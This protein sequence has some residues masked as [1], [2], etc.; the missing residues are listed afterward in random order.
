MAGTLRGADILARALAEAGVRHLFSLSGNQIMPVYDAAPDAGLA[1]VH[2]RHEGAAVHMADAWGRLTGEPGI[3]LV[4]GGPGHAN[5]M[6][7][8]YTALAAESPLVLLSGHAPL[9]ELGRG[10]FQEM[11]QAQLA[12]PL[13]KA[14]WTAD[15]PAALGSVVTRALQ[16]ARSG[17]PG[18]VHVS[19]PF[20][21]LEAKVDAGAVELPRPAVAASQPLSEF[22]ADAVL[23]ELQRAKRPLVLAGSMMANGP[24][25]AARERLTAALGVPVVCMESPRGVNDPCLGA[26]ADVLREA[27]LLLLL[28]KQPDFTLRF[29]AAPAIAMDCRF[30]VLDPEP[31]ALQRTLKTLAPAQRV[32]LSAVADPL[33]AAEALLARARPSGTREWVRE[34]ESAVGF[35]PVEWNTLTSRDGEPPHPVEIGR[36][37]QQ[38]L[39]RAR[40]PVL[41]ADGGEFGQW[42][43]ACVNAP[44][45]LI[46]GPAGSIGSAIPFAL[47]ARVA[48]PDATVVAMLGDGTFGFHLA[49][50]DTAVRARLPFLAVIGN[51]AC[52]NAEH[53]IQLR[54]Y[55]R[56]RA[57]GCELLPARYDQAAAALGGHGEHVTRAAELPAALERALAS[58]R[59]ACV[60]VMIER[61]PAPVVA[62]GAAQRAGAM[63]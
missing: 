52:W 27:D 17:R 32:A 30:I 54:T 37:V 28:G 24:A 58:R 13:T 11:A 42:A 10:A 39:D 61:L 23:E 22:A 4:T 34:V 57:H 9:S 62:R 19:L 25:R 36:A 46:N 35:R 26:F 29:G 43:Q 2:V 16:V 5:A 15:D 50:F 33:V 14:S 31:A 55:G 45:R 49:E 60:N 1:I 53:Q 59:P 40:D 21:V 6:G 8:L 12:A 7:A 20:D 41:V 18:P 38:I 51:D 63:H 3:A 56:D 48:R 47:A 44:T